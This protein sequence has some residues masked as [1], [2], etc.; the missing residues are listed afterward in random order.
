M[1]FAAPGAV[2]R[3]VV[4]TVPSLFMKTFLA[5]AFVA[6]TFLRPAGFV[7]VE[8]SGV[9]HWE[10]TT[11]DSGSTERTAFSE[12]GGH[13]GDCLDL[14]VSRASVPTLRHSLAMPT[15]SV[16]LVPA[17]TVDHGYVTALQSA[18]ASAPQPSC[19][20]HLSST[21]IRR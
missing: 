14:T 12:A 8:A 18:L 9:V 5:Y 19:A 2:V 15:A 10:Y 7:C 20:R 1:F 21:V 3:P 6:V 16:A 4:Y 11:C 17:P 13:C